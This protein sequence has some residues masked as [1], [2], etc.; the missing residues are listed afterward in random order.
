MRLPL[1]FASVL[2]LGAVMSLSGQTPPPDQESDLAGVYACEGT[3]PNN[4]TYKGTVEILRYENAYHVRWSISSSEE[5]LGIGVLNGDVLAVSYFGG[6]PGVVVYRIE[7][8]AQGP[9]LV[10]QWTVVE[11]AGQVFMET[12]TRVSLDAGEVALPRPPRAK[13][14]PVQG[15][16]SI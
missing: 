8:Q 16:R 9:R 4:I 3:G 11:A 2:T 6:V 12:L 10:G 13:P 14:H 15:G 7:R 1:L 5:Y